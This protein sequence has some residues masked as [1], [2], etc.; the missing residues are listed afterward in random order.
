MVFPRNTCQF[1][2]K[3]KNLINLLEKLIFRNF[4]D[5]FD[6]I[7]NYSSFACINSVIIKIQMPGFHSELYE[8]FD[9][10]HRN[11]AIFRF[12]ICARTK[13]AVLF[14]AAARGI[15]M[16]NTQQMAQR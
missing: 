15:Y 3:K 4:H 5:K 1:Q 16:W 7:I 9:F 6:K 12:S 13:H 2:K 14:V 8:V 10:S 11:L